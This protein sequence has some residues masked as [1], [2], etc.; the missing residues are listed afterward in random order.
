MKVVCEKSTIGLG[1]YPFGVQRPSHSLLCW[2]WALV[3]PP[4]LPHRP[5]FHLVLQG[6]TLGWG[7]LVVMEGE[8]E[9]TAYSHLHSPLGTILQVPR[10]HGPSSQMVV[11]P[12][13]N[14]TSSSTGPGSLCIRDPLF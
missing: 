5:L 11:L 13:G 8:R 3:H 7:V 9:G 1:L 12:V 4:S 10:L 2:L 14:D 6:T